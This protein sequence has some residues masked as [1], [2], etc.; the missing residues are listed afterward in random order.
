M[1]KWSI[2]LF[3]SLAFTACNQDEYTYALIETDFGDIKVKLYNTTPQHRDNFIKLAEEGFYDGTLFHRVIPGFMIQGGDPLSKDAA[4][5]QRLGMGGPGYEIDAEIGGLHLRGALAA[6]RTPN[7][8]KRSSGS[9]FYIV[10]GS[11]V[12]TN[13]LNAHAARNN[14]A[15]SAV[16]KELYLEM[17]GRPDLDFNYTV[18]GEVVEGLEVVDK[19]AEVNRDPNDRPREDIPMKVRV[20]N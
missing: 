12:D 4:P 15:Y 2:I 9:Q 18:F 16:Q 20:V 3:F 13:F 7:P 11:P 17:G 10:Q 6:A 19:I 14:A 8:Q 1:K 5:G